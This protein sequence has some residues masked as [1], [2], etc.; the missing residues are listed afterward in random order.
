M[1][2]SVSNGASASYPDLPQ[3]CEHCTIGLN[4]QSDGAA[5][6]KERGDVRT[7]GARLRIKENVVTR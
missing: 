1:G 5:A 4:A 7:I 3:N 2:I 6:S